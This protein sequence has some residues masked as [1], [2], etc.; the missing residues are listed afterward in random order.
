MSLNLKQNDFKKSDLSER[1]IEINGSKNL[2]FTK[3]VF[4]SGMLFKSHNKWWGDFGE[5][6]NAYTILDD[7]GP[8]NTWEYF[9]VNT[10]IAPVGTTGGQFE[11][12]ATG[13]AD[14]IRDAHCRYYADYLYQR[15]EDKKK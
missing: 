6:S 10:G 12:E 14:A 13:D 7:V 8:M 4:Y 2:G 11:L 9:S 15:V 5:V 3:W 1:L